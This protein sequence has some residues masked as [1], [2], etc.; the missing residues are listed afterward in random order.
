MADQ[1]DVKGRSRADTE[2][3]ILSVLEGEGELPLDELMDVLLHFGR[4]GSDR[5]VDGWAELLQDTLSARGAGLDMLQ[6]LALRCEWHS[7]EPA[8]KKICSDAVERAFTSRLGKVLFKHAGFNDDAIS[9]AE[10][11]RRMGVLARLEAGVFCADKTWGFGVVRRVDDFYARVTIDFDSKRAHEMTMAYA[12]ETLE[13]VP[14][15]HFLVRWHQ[16]ADAIREMV[17]SDAAALVCLILDSYGELNVDAIKEHLVERVMPDSQW[18]KFW[19]AARK[20]LKAD[21]LVHLPPKRSEPIK[22]LESADEHA[23]AEFSALDALREPDAILKK[24]DAME[25]AGL[26]G[27]LSPARKQILADRLAFAVWGAEDR[28]PALA[29]RALLTAERLALPSENGRLGEREVDVN[30]VYASVL[31]RAEL[32]DVL[33]ALPVRMMTT[34]VERLMSTFPEQAS[35]RLLAML[36]SLSVP[37]LQE[38]L[39]RLLD[40]SA[41]EALAKTVKGYLQAR[42]T[43]PALIVWLLRHP[44]DAI[45]MVGDDLAELLRQGV[46]ALEYPLAGEMLKAQHQLRGLYESGDWLGQQLDPLTPEQR[47]VFVSK[48]MQSRGWDET[49][50]RSVLAGII[51]RFP[52]LQS[53]VS[54][55]ANDATP[56]ARARMTS[57]RSYRQRQAQ[58]KRLMEI[59]IPENAR[60]IAVARSYGDLRENA[61]FKYAK[62]HQR[63]LYRRRDEMEQDLELVKGTDFAGCDCEVAGM[64]TEVE[65]KRSNGDSNRYR[66]LGEWDRDEDLNIISSLSQVAKQLEGH[67]AGDTLTLPGATGE[68]R[69]EVVAVEALGEAVKAWLATEAPLAE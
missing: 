15:S 65:V 50:R 7:H 43:G 37:V 41:A 59:E 5:R 48:L 67:R 8:F 56:K 22:L 40:S 35:E 1:R 30:A 36:S 3:W 27:E 13:L 55:P 49:G 63:I 11:V 6:V 58:L 64:G 34:V 19:D 68:D 33:H 31:G 69:C 25:A 66:I 44:D 17:K 9:A 12:A 52:E 53:L 46:D 24:V 16:D 42:N 54:G 38:A 51:K 18:K 60:E 39:P 57:W 62:E 14:D 4:D 61:E 2:M 47:T 26:L 21:P 28:Q 23:S 20:A 45:R 10:A 29:L 32:L